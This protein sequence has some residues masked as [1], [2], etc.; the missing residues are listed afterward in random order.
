MFSDASILEGEDQEKY[1]N[2][3]PNSVRNT[4]K[5]REAKVWSSLRLVLSPSTMKRG[6]EDQEG[7]PV[8]VDSEP[9]EKKKKKK[10]KKRKGDSKEEEEDREKKHV[11]FE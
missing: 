2:S 3:L 8:L 10:S 6:S 1:W 11:R 9:I 4:S 5:K 7:S